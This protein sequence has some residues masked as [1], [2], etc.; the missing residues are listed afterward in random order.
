MANR[1]GF[2]LELKDFDWYNHD[3]VKISQEDEDRVTEII[4]PFLFA[5]TKAELFEEALREGILLAPA[6]TAKDLAENHQLV[7]REF[8]VY[9]EHPELG[10]TILYPGAPV[11]LSEMPWQVR[12]R[13]PLIGEHNDEV[14]IQEMGISKEDLA[15][16][17]MTE[18]I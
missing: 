12:R 6:S 10:H 3:A 11:K 16:L 5:K 4:M 9:V 17:K 13:P 2:A 7:S 14:Y 15:L 18:V 1:E 8:W